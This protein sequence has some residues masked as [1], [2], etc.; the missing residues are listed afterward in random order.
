QPRRMI[1]QEVYAKASS[2]LAQNETLTYQTAV[3]P[4]F[5]DITEDVT[6]AVQ[7]SG[8]RNGLVVVFSRHTTAAIKIN[9]YEPELLKDMAR[10]LEEVAPI[11]RDYCHNDFEVRTVNMTE[12]E[13]PNAH[14]H[15]QH[16]ILSASESVPV[17][18][19]RLT[20]GRW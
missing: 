6:E 3:A 2:F 14:S 7:H 5:L 18:D 9:E 1:E 20:L 16:L 11:D 19:G 13:C 12:D 8:V 10:F 17:V 4:Q 15:C